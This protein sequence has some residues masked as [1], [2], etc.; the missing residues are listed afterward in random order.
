MLR[1]LL[2]NRLAAFERTYGYDTT[3]MR[4]V[5]DADPRAFLA[6]AR[7]GAMSG[8]RRDVAKDVWFAAKLVGAM[9]EDC[10]P[11]TQLVVAMALR[12]GVD[13]RTIA[14]VVRGDLA[15]LSDDV[16]LGV[17]FA[18]AALAHS[19]DADERRDEIVRRWGR[20]ALISLAYAMTSARIYPTVKYA[21][22]HGA[23]CQRVDVAGEP[24]A[25]V[26]ASA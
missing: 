25:V 17:T 10:G 12:D 9:T 11:C 21:L 24:V 26:R 19:P 20:R 1:W 18:R 15:A 4:E 5:I 22:G 13:P 7:V 2:R 8:Y 16:L 23:A 14:A 6:I 3:Y